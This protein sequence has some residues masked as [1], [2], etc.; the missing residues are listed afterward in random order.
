M[1]KPADQ[2]FA[3]F[4]IFFALVT[5]VRAGFEPIWNV[6][7]NPLICIFLCLEL[8]LVKVNGYRIGYLFMLYKNVKL[9][10]I[11]ICTIL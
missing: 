8:C 4:F 6:L 3:G 2:K 7:A 5:A 10:K 9:A 11:F 1:K